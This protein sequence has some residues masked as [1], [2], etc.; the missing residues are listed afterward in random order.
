MFNNGFGNRNVAGMPNRPNSVSG[1]NKAP[2]SISGLN[3]MP[4][5]K[6]PFANVKIDRQLSKQIMNSSGE[7]VIR[8]KINSGNGGYNGN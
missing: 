6:D 4:T 3:K 5:R 2:T 7:N 1:I 8:N